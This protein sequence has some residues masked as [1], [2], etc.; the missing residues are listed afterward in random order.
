MI[1]QAVR[2]ATPSAMRVRAAFLALVR[3]LRRLGLDPPFICLPLPAAPGL[4]CART[5][6]PS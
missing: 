1:E 3:P 4:A 2:P 5:V 6:S